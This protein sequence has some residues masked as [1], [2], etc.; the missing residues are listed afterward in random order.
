MPNKR[1]T[2]REA[3]IARENADKL[4][5]AE[6]AARLRERIPERAIRLSDAP[7]DGKEPRPGADPA[8]IHQMVMAWTPDN[9]D[10]KDQWTWGQ[11]RQWAQEDWD[12]IILPKLT[13]WETM[14]WYEIEAAIT[15]SGRRMHHFMDTDTICSEAQTR[16]VEIEY[17]GDSIYR[18]RLG[19]KR[20]LWGH[21][22]VEK[23]HIVWFD[24]EHKIYPTDVD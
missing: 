14:K 21:R 1:P 2:R 9:A 20:R 10:V 18:F 24:P 22:I 7:P 11:A 8:S 4:K 13:S 5:E 23:F 6:K 17:D 19:N 15:D 12:K 16:L 3:R